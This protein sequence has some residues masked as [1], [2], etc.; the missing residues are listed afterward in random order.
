MSPSRWNAIKAPDDTED[1]MRLDTTLSRLLEGGRSL[2]FPNRCVGC[3]A[4]IDE[5]RWCCVD[6]AHAVFGIDGPMCLRCG[7]PRSTLG[8]GYVGVDEMCG[9][10]LQEPPGFERARARWEYSGVIA[11][12]MQ[13]AKYRRRPSVLKRLAGPLGDWLCERL[14]HIATAGC[15]RRPIAT[16]VPM[17]PADLRDRGFNAALTLFRLAAPR[18][19]PVRDAVRKVRRTPAQAGLGRAER[20]KNLRGAFACRRAE[21]VAGRDVI[22][23]DDVMTTGATADAVARALKKAGADNVFVLTAARAVSHSR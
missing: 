15:R 5:S 20:R 4:Y 21:M 3:D 19:W 12:A 11:E 2:L 23:F 16:V 1:P 6:C 10:C 22:L 17:H 7:H 8:R 13:R 14:S 18:G 9:R